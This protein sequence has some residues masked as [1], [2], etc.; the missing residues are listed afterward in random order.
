MLYSAGEPMIGQGFSVPQDV[1]FPQN[2]EVKVNHTEDV[3]WNHKGL[4]NKPGSAQPGD[5]TAFVRKQ[6]GFTNNVGVMYALTSKRFY[7]NVLLVKRAT[8]EDLTKVLQ[9]KPVISKNRVVRESEHIDSIGSS[10]ADFV[11]VL[12]K[13]ADPDIEATSTNMSLKDPIS[14]LRMTMP[15]R[16]NVC[17]HNQCFD[18]FTFLDMQQQG[19]TWTCPICSKPVTFTSL[20]IDEYV[21]D[22]LQ[23]APNLDQVTLDPDGSWRPVVEQNDNRGTKRPY[24]D[25]DE[26]SDDL[27]ELSDYR[28]IGLKAEP[29]ATPFSFGQTPPQFSPAPG[30]T[31]RN[32]AGS[33]RRS[34]VIDLTLSDGDDEP[35]AKR[36]H[37]Q[38]SMSTPSLQSQVSNGFRTSSMT[39]NG[40]APFTLPTNSTMTRSAET[41][42][43]L[44][45]PPRPPSRAQPPPSMF[46][47]AYWQ[48]TTNSFG[49]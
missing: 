25:D 46:E 13:A 29:P 37:I 45:Q 48:G 12:A 23:G 43:G 8:P 19:P 39:P 49:S 40:M 3:K 17:A 6:P 20:H 11:Q 44:S 30:S 41:S 10:E 31:T 2:M 18:A 24:D 34:E 27:I 36:P 47:D 14:M 32:G 7:M 26:D 22:I 33:K 5:L 38:P 16:S 1:S 28:P 9:K 4:K 21:Q 15:V 42:H 35:P